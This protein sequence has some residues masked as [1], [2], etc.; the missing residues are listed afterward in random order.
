MTPTS[1]LIF[2]GAGILAG[3]LAGFL[4]I[5]GG[6]VLVPLLLALGYDYPQAI[7]TSSLSIVITASSGTLQNWH[8]NTFNSKRV[9]MIGLPALVTAQIGVYFTK[10]FPDYWLKAAFGILL[11]VNIYLVQLRKF[12]KSQQQQDI[13]TIGS[14][15]DSVSWVSQSSITSIATGS[16]A[17]IL[18]GLFGIG[19]GVIMVPL[20]ILLLGETIK[21]AI[22]TSLAVVV[23]TSTSACLGH[24]V[25][26]NVLWIEGLILGIGGFGGAQIS[27]RFLPK[28]SNEVVTLT[29][30]IYLGMLSIYFFWKAWQ[31]YSGIEV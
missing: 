18:A 9:L 12:L 19:G 29:F 17:G 31:S 6:T 20:Q 11:L 10:L 15:K 2:A 14:N 1:F 30:Q 3:I 16:L 25:N 27:T 4:G 24:A 23:I 7:A 13:Q 28:L 21:T 26:D 5:G 22:Q 8:Q